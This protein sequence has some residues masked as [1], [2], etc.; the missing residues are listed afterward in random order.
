MS[1]LKPFELFAV[2]L[3]GLLR[4]P[5]QPP[6]PDAQ[7]LPVAGRQ[8]PH[9][10]LFLGLKVAGAGVARR[11]IFSGSQPRGRSD[12]GTSVADH[13]R[14][15][16]PSFG[17]TPLPRRK[18]LARPAVRDEQPSGVHPPRGQLGEPIRAYARRIEVMPWCRTYRSP[19][20]MSTPA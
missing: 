12:Q 19:R 6:Q 16:W 3:T 15:C 9:V 14:C 20:K 18:R 11:S 17:K 4:V 5:A 7:R 2:S 1:A 8:K 10:L 13:A